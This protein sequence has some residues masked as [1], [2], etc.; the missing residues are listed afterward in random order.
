ME[1]KSNDTYSIHKG[2]LSSISIGLS[3]SGGGYRAAAFHLGTLAYLHHINLLPQ[4]RRLSTVSGGTFTGAKY[5][6]SLVEGNDFSEFFREFYQFLLNNPLFKGGLEDFQK[7]ESRNIL[8]QRKL[9]RSMAN[10]Y[11]KSFLRSSNGTAYTFGQIMN[12]NI[13]VEEVVFNATEF[14]TGN[15]FRFWKSENPR[16]KFGN[17]S[18]RISK[19]VAKE[20]R[21]A[22]IVAASSCFP[23]AFE[24][25]KFPQDFVWKD[26]N[27]IK[28]I[29]DSI[30][31]NN[32][33]KSV[34]LMDGGIFDNLGLDS[35]LRPDNWENAQPLDIYII[36]DVDAANDNIFSYPD[37]KISDKDTSDDFLLNLMPQKIKISIRN[38]FKIF[39]DRLYNLT[40]EQVSWLAWTILLTCAITI[41]SI[42]FEVW[43]TF[44]LGTFF[45]TQHLFLSL[46]PLF[47]VTL[48][49]CGLWWARRL[50]Y[51]LINRIPGVKIGG[52][53]NLKT[54][55]VKELI[56]LLELRYK[57]MI[58][59]VKSIF[60]KRIRDLTHKQIYNIKY[61]RKIISNRIDKVD[62]KDFYQPI[63]QQNTL[64]AQFDIAL[65]VGTTLW[66]EEGK[67]A[68][69][70]NALIIAGQASIC[71]H[72]KQYVERQ[73]VEEEFKNKALHSLFNKSNKDWKKLV[74]NQSQDQAI[75]NLCN[76]LQKDLRKLNEH[77]EQYQIIQSL[78]SNITNDWEKLNEYPNSLL[79]AQFLN[80]K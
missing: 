64:K 34:A 3:L 28:D 45:F 54:L 43:T 10:F 25:L 9:I 78:L 39:E 61:H 76:E 66:L 37:N 57:S 33:E 60:M 27:I 35:L 80:I 20:I 32:K 74:E 65:S 23:A 59:L 46:V 69:Q 62:R 63:D 75:Q 13:P 48:I 30:S 11:E 14:R 52:W 56:Y 36:S 19:E 58:V 5:I 17:G 79:D 12:S 55:T 47:L 40:L 42:S 2:N 49:L 4:V 22:D 6:L 7:S 21:V 8:G 29:E 71:F 70:L 68:Q 53:N 31:E 24:P 67:E 51:D 26:K 41:I 15:A 50:I 16:A 18:V 73:S 72:L 44:K 1:K 38:L 77:D